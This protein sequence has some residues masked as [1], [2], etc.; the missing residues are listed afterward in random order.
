MPALIDLQQSPDVFCS[1]IAKIDRLP[2]GCLR[3]VH[4]VEQTTAS[5]K[6]ERLVVAKTVW[7][8]A[9]LSTAMRQ[10]ALAMTEDGAI[11]VDGGGVTMLH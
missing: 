1:G 5:G 4:Y 2:G 8:I 9:A 3:F 7:P 11:M 10:T 6:V